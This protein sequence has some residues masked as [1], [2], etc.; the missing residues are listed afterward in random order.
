M[1]A[2]PTE[3]QRHPNILV[4]HTDQHRADCLGAYGNL[5]IQTPHLDALALDSVRYDHCFCPY[6]VC[7]PS[8]YSLISGLYVHEHRGRTN[9]STMLP[10]TA[11][12]PALL[13]DAGYR[14]R[15][16]GK[17]HYTPTYYDVGFQE[18]TLAEQD[19]VGRWDDDYHRWLREQGLVDANDLEDQRREYRERARPEY[20]ETYGA[21][22]SNLPEEAHSTT[23]IAQR[24]LDAVADWGPEGNLLMV[25]FVKPHHP[26][27]P[28]ASWAQMYDPRYT[29]IL[30][31]WTD[32][33]SSQDA[34]FYGGYF[35]NATL[36]AD[37]MRR[38][39]AYYYATVSQIDYWVGRILERLKA[40]GLYDGTMI[41]FTSDHGE[42]LG[43]HHLLL[44]GS[45]LYDPLGRV[46]LMVKWPYQTQRAGTSEALVSVV[47]VAPTILSAAG[48]APA[49]AMRGQD[50]A[51]SVDREVVFAEG[52]SPRA[53]QRRSGPELMARTATHKLLLNR[54]APEH[55]LLFDLREDPYELQNRYGDPA[56]ASVQEALTA[57]LAG[58]LPNADYEMHLDERAPRIA[59]PNVPDL[60]DGHREE[61]AAW[62]AE[63]M[64]DAR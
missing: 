56:L 61:I 41:I 50:L 22:P 54:T 10:G 20:W 62:Y 31:G 21:M 24:A 14:T 26:F 4:I 55:S 30:P 46:P 23:W 19:G 59:Q 42:Y 11:T 13:A 44:K 45:H 6:P 37:T 40:E 9:H 49:P 51:R 60:D 38:V 53:D 1:S 17:M 28:P 64:A 29:Q 27:D 48:L 52:S 16:V 8:R 25:G 57:A 15:A 32:E 47:D 36:G 58:W 39:T 33:V 5:H 63:Q 35:D 7:T 34:A 43:Y 12:F 18:M 2:H 3:P